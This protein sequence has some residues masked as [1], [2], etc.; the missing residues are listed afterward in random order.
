MDDAILGRMN[1]LWHIDLGWMHGCR[2]ISGRERGVRLPIINSNGG[3]P[4]LWNYNWRDVCGVFCLILVNVF[5]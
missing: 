4:R 5:M 2:R 1:R 3:D